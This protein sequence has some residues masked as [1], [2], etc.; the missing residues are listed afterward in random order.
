MI[1]IPMAGLSRR[2]TVAGYTVPKYMLPLHGTSVFCR[3]VG[4]FE[5]L[6]E[7]TPFLFIAR[8]LG[9]TEAF[10]RRECA[11]LGIVDARIVILNRETAGQAETVEL[12]LREIEAAEYE[13]ITIFNIDTFRKGFQYPKARWFTNSD[14]FIEVFRGAGSNW[15][16]V[17]PMA[18][19]EE[20][21]AECTAEKRP[22]SDLC[23]DGLYHFA[24]ASDFLAALALERAEPS[25][26]ELY[27]APLYN[28]L[29]A[30]GRR[31]H[32]DLVSNEV[33]TFCGVPSEY[34]AVLNSK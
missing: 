26:P 8:P 9:Q 4:S 28:H 32:Y 33:L 13:P 34:E 14:G 1:V 5:A 22:I 17:G 6:F 24:R 30:R 20:P 21:L 3:A 10:I 15:S 11:N 25:M 16:Y 27:V 18:G 29:I 23:C 19:T 12:G 31:I 2:F 7:T